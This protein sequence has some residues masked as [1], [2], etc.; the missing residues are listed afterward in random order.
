MQLHRLAPAAAA[1]IAGAGLASMLSAQAVVRYE[2]PSAAILKVM[3]APRPPRALMS[4]QRDYLLLVDAVPNP[5]I[6]EL[7]EPMLRIAGIRIDPASNGIHA[8]ARVRNLRLVRVSDGTVRPVAL[9]RAL[10]HITAPVWA[11]DGR[12][13]AFANITRHGIEL[14]VGDTATA[15]AHQVTGVQLNEVTGAAFAFA[16]PGE[17]L[18]KLVPSR[19][20]PAP[21]APAVPI[22]P[23]VS[24]SD[25]HA[26]PAPTYEDLLK[27]PHQEDLF[28]FYATS[29]LAWVNL[30]TGQ[31]RPVGRPGIYAEARPSPDRQ[32]ILVAR[33][34][35]PYSYL[36]PDN[37]FPR[38]WAIWSASGRQERA[39]RDQPLEGGRRRG[40][41]DPGPRGWTW[42][43]LEPATLIYETA[44]DG[45]NPSRPAPFR[46]QVWK[47]AP[48]FQGAGQAW[49][50]TEWRFAGLQWGSAGDLAL[51]RE[52]DRR[53]GAR[54]YF[55]APASP[56]QMRLAWTLAPQ[57]RYDDPGAA[58]A[59]FGPA[60]AQHAAS[61]GGRGGSALI[62]EDHG[63]IY[64]QGAGSSNTGDHPFLDRL[65]TAS[66]RK[67]RLFQSPAGSYDT[68]AD[69]LTPD[70]A[71]AVISHESV[72][73]PPNLYVRDLSA[74]GPGR[75]LTHYTDP[76]PE[77]RQIKKQLIRYQ[78]PSDG[79]ELSTMVYLPPDYQPGTRYP[80]IVWAYPSE[81]ATAKAAGQVTGSADRFTILTG[82]SQ[83]YLALDG[84]VVLDNMTMPILSKDDNV[85][86]AN[87]TYVQQLV[88]DAAAGVNAAAHLGFIDPNRVGVA[89][90]SYGAFMVGNLLAHSTLFKAGNAQ[91]GA[92]N[93]TLTP[94]GFQN[95]ERT[96]WQDP[97]LYYAMSPFDFADKI[98]APILLTHGMADSNSGTF[99][100]QSERLYAAVQGLGGTI[101]F[102][103]LP[104]EAHGY[105][106]QQTIET[107]VAEMDNWFNKY[108]KN[109][110]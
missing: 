46:D 44:L 57:D 21:A 67:Q 98:K 81:F 58:L 43:P 107:V 51:L 110:Q 68:V 40:H 19:R 18:C 66:L 9:A 25:G 52:S 73:D 109:A 63:A 71:R 92:Y 85:R 93:R 42:A 59:A 103:Y 76:A 26:L 72:T 54:T 49:F 41:I 28:D 39:L 22:G 45:G 102:V 47:L 34:H 48:P 3:E 87:D 29:Q 64:L 24:E 1:L 53:R 105:L 91:S 33:I 70:G 50:K 82:Y 61:G 32:H 104:F 31:V 38:A 62:E 96:Y 5:D 23:T 95:E 89:G 100:I 37:E 35:R 74:A 12:R 69:L 36:V 65:D 77:V 94:F 15:R 6:A 90:H 2:Q 14:W 13:F 20:R 30:A 78:R 99:P 108:V 106:A 86:D 75:A 27:N 83:L 16:S 80:A 88:E 84:Y 55:F 79:V 60:V 10:E 101:R 97:Q 7:A 56:D 11:P 4:P 17:L 8:S